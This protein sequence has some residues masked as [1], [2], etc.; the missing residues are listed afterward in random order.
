MSNEHEPRIAQGTLY[1]DTGRSTHEF[2]HATSAK[3]YVRE[4]G[5]TVLKALRGEET[6]RTVRMGQV[7]DWGWRDE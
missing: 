2:P 4:N 6:L 5:D 1:I 3:R 7:E